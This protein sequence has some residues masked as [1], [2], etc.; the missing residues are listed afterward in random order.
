LTI[1]TVARGEAPP[2][3]PWNKPAPPL[4]RILPLLWFVAL[5][6]AIYAMRT[7]RRVPQLRRYAAIV[8]LILLLITGAVMAGCAGKMN[9]TPAGTSQ[10]TVTATSGTMSQT[11]PANSVALT[12]Q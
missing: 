3:L 11:T 10:L 9:G 1:T 7:V 12:V 2:S 5:L 8:P 6:A 4:L